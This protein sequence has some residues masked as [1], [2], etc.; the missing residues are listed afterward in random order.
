M[1]SRSLVLLFLVITTM[2]A[3]GLCSPMDR[4]K[5]SV[6][7]SALSPPGSEDRSKTLSDELGEFVDARLAGSGLWGVS[8]R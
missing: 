8:V 2:M 1:T 4:S 3:C 6:P 5:V 7:L